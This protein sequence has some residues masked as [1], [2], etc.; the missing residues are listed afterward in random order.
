MNKVDYFLKYYRTMETRCHND[1][2][3]ENFINTYLEKIYIINLEENRSRREYIKYVMKKLKINCTIVIVKKINKNVYRLLQEEERKDNEKLTKGEMG[4]YLSHMWCLNNAIQNN[5]NKFLILEDDVIIHKKFHQLF[6]ELVKNKE[7]DFLM[8]GASHFRYNLN[9]YFIKDGIY[10]PSFDNLKGNLLGAFACM[11][12]LECA[13]YLFNLRRQEITYFDN[14]LYNLFK[15][16]SSTSGICNPNLVIADVSNSNLN[17]NFGIMGLDNLNHYYSD[18]YYNINFCDYHYIFLDMFDKYKFFELNFNDV[19]KALACILLNY[20]NNNVKLVQMYL[21]LIDLKFFD[22]DIINTLLETA[23]KD[24]QYL[25]EHKNLLQISDLFQVT[26]GYLLTSRKNEFRYMCLKYLS[27]IRKMNLPKIKLNKHKESVLIEYRILPHLEFLIRNTIIKL[28]KDWSHTVVCGKENHEFMEIICKN[29]SENIKVIN[30]GHSNVN[31]QVYS[32]MLTKSE[33]WSMFKG[34][35]LLIYQEDSCIFNN[36][37]GNFLKWDYIGS[38]WCK[39]KDDIVYNSSQIGNGGF[40]L[41][42]K[43]I[44]IHI[45]DNYPIDKEPVSNEDMRYMKTFKFK[46][47]PEDKYFSQVMNRENI[48]EIADWYTARE[49]AVES[50]GTSKSFGGHQFWIYDHAWKN[51]M[52]KLNQQYVLLTNEKLNISEKKIVEKNPVLFHKIAVNESNFKSKIAYTIINKQKMK[53]NY[54]S[55]LHCYDINKFYY[56]YGNYLKTIS[57]LSDVIVTYC[58]GSVDKKLLDE[59]VTILE[60]SNKGMDIGSK[61]VCVEYLKKVKSNYEYILFLHSKTNNEMRNHWFDCLVSNLK[62]IKET[63]DLNV[64][65][66]FPPCIFSGNS[67]AIMWK[68]NVTF[69]ADNLYKNLYR[70]YHYNEL[71]VEELINYFKLNGNDIS[72]FPDGN[73]YI[74]N[75]KI[76]K[77]LFGDRKLY[78]ILNS[79]DS[80]DYN[81]VKTVYKLNYDDIFLVY[82]TYKKNNFC[83]NN[84]EFDVEKNF[85]DGMIEHSFERLLFLIIKKHNLKIQLVDSNPQFKEYYDNIT[86]MINNIYDKR[87]VY[88]NF[89]WKDYL[90]KNESALGKYDLK[91]KKNVWN[92]YCRSID[93]ELENK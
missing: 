28:G 33:F 92:S 68:D 6:E 29:I 36:N 56:M 55:H 69:K 40:S 81:W 22:I 58:V 64:G 13:K 4:T 48:G 82:D 1:I 65:G 66:Y 38:P 41:R 70:K 26:P 80:F 46:N 35:K 37:V 44:M 87:I 50:Y 79:K 83:G 75:K 17:H 15:I 31:R 84:L 93:Y 7:Y 89:D 27:N 43:N 73:C 9:T 24:K 30:T 61:F 32:D 5:Y 72:I 2:E 39:K 20:F 25:V 76:A 86:N 14:N 90:S 3:E 54:V 19:K 47:I 10:K 78:N 88:K 49:F 62:K 18:C 57:S 21:Y 91:T 16:F 52:Y 11:Y 23:S 77:N 74:L 8:L 85:P 12:S 59:K 42:T 53:N 63:N 51:R 34:Q 45:C 60:I 67:K 71:Y